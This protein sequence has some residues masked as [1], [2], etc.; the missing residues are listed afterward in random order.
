VEY[1]CNFDHFAFNHTITI[2]GGNPVNTF[3]MDADHNTSHGTSVMGMLGGRA[4]Q[5]RGIEGI[6]KD[7]DLLFSPVQLGLWPNISDAI[8]RAAVAIDEGDIIVIEQQVGG[9]FY[10]IGESLS[11]GSQ[12]GLVCV[13]WDRPCYDAIVTAVDAGLLVVEAAGNGAGNF[14]AEKYHRDGINRGYNPFSRDFDSGAIIV[15][16][17]GSSTQ[18][19]RASSNFGVR[20]DLQGWGD[21][22][23][24]SSGPGADSDLF[25]SDGVNKQYTNTFGGTS[26]AT[27]IV[28]GAAAIAQQAFKT[29]YGRPGTC[30]EIRSILIL[31]G[32]PQTPNSNGNIQHIGPLPDVKKAVDRIQGRIS[33]PRFLPDGSG[34][35]G[36]GQQVRLSFG[37]GTNTINAQ[38]RFTRDASEPTISSPRY[39]AGVTRIRLTRSETIKAKTFM[40]DDIDGSTNTSVT[41][42]AS[43]QIVDS[44][45]P[46]PSLRDDGRDNYSGKHIIKVNVPA[47]FIIGVNAVLWYNVN[48][49]ADP[50]PFDTTTNA[51]LYVGSIKLNHGSVYTIRARWCTFDANG[52]V[53]PGPVSQTVFDLT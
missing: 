18:T 45:L 51:S 24:T 49:T 35:V 52:A 11:T 12:E 44:S 4:R 42:A 1:N 2:V 29:R 25:T 28:A 22:I 30:R 9:P 27:P 46:V 8:S 32:H 47:A 14:D 50:V 40:I 6:A 16:S 19:K 20:V 36:P 17:G 13:E 5:N 31:T 23:V 7:A 15:G 38:I 26:G 21:S 41:V 10:D 43:F 39:R 34:I 3:G 48:Q 37:P 33:P 53:V